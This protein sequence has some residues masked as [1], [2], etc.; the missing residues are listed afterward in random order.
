MPVMAVNCDHNIDPWA[1]LISP[2]DWFGGK[3]RR[4]SQRAQKAISLKFY[5]KC[6]QI[7]AKWRFLPQSSL[8]FIGP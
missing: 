6:R 7:V 3:W 1:K 5:R 2:S 4:S 8:D